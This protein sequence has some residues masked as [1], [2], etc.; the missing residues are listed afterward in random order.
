MAQSGPRDHA[1]RMSAFGGKSGKLVDLDYFPYL[2]AATGSVALTASDTQRGHGLPRQSVTLRRLSQEG[3]LYEQFVRL[4]GRNA[5]PNR[6]SSWSRQP[7]CARTVTPK[8]AANSELRTREY[9]TEAEVERL[10]AAARKNRLGAPGCH[11]DRRGLQA[12][13]ASV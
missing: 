5:R 13:L 12:W 6:I 4:G 2:A 8:R 1:D 3:L 9:L 7:P 11:H 10:M